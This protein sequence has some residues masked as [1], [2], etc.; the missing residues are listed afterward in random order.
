MN[1]TSATATYQK[2]SLESLVAKASANGLITMLLD[3]ALVRIAQA[4]VQMEQGN[5]QRQ[6]E[7]IGKVIDIVASLDS[8]L[9]HEK[10]GEVSANLEALYDYVVRQLFQANV[11]SDVQLLEECESLLGEIRVGWIAM[12]EQQRDA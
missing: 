5:K 1:A 10:G 12:D 3:G 8:Y 11:K 4:K 9:D 6:G 2:A 7:I